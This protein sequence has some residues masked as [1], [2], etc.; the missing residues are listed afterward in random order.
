MKP[1]FTKSSAK[2]AWLGC[3]CHPAVAIRRETA[4][5]RQEVAPGIDPEG[6][7]ILDAPKI[8]IQR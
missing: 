7:A 1:C 5:R 2:M 8:G 4:I 6:L 3:V